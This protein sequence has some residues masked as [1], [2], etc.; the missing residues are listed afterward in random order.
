[1]SES[2][3]AR[4]SEIQD[5]GALELIA[6]APKACYLSVVFIINTLRCL[7]GICLRAELTNSSSAC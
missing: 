3:I 1:M 4:A 5:K 7:F 6:A 2:S